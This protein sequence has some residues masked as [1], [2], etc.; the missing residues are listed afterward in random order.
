MKFQ[1]MALALE[2]CVVEKFLDQIDMAQQ[3]SSA[4]VSFQ[5]QSIEGV[6]KMEKAKQL[7]S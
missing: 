4:A 2:W 5:S 6:T 1:A 7:V 3:H